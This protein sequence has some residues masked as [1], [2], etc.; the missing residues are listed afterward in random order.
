LIPQQILAVAGAAT[1]KH[2]KQKILCSGLSGKSKKKEKK[3][4]SSVRA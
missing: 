1:A 2:K 4:H 3:E